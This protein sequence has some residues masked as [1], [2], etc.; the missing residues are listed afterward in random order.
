MTSPCPN[1]A[2]FSV[3]LEGASYTAA[4][5]FSA[6]FSGGDLQALAS[7]FPAAVSIVIVIEYYCNGDY[8]FRR[9]DEISGEGKY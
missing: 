9:M 8:S 7:G 3:S 1:S 5:S 6:A 2:T 4:L